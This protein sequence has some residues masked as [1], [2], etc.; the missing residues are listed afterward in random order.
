[1]FLVLLV[2]NWLWG[3]H[4]CHRRHGSNERRCLASNGRVFANEVIGEADFESCRSLEILDVLGGELDL[5][6]LDV[7]VEMLDFAAADLK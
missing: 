1:M 5:E 6:R 2:P 4:P 3:S 7:L